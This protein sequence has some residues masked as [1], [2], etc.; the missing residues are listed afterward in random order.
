MA[1]LSETF[2]KKSVNYFELD[3]AHY[4]FTPRYSWDTML[5]FTEVYLKQISDIEKHQFVGDVL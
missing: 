3:T 1:C 2:R 5:R 4:L